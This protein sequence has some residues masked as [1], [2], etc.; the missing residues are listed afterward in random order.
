VGVGGTLESAARAGRYGVGLAL[1]ILGGSPARFK[2]LADEYYL[3]ANQ[4]GYDKKELK[5]TV[6]GHA[7]IGETTQ[8]AN[9]E[10]FPYYANYW[11]YVNGQRGLGTQISRKDFEIMSAPDTALFVGSPQQMIEKILQQ[12]ELFG[13][14]RFIAQMDIGGL[15]FEKI[16]KNIERLATEVAPVIRRETQK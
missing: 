3:A 16:A 5:V 15:P 2:P 9:E 6:T 4:A 8:K 1:A 11:R 12:N 14:Q 10:F 13:H 7:F